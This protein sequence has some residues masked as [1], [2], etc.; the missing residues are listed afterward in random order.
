MPTR[1]RGLCRHLYCVSGRRP[2]VSQTETLRL[3]VAPGTGGSHPRLGVC[4]LLVHTAPL[5]RPP[6][7]SKLLDPQRG[8]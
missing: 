5:K 8:Q 2:G 1:M 3:L 4:R 6:P 7:F